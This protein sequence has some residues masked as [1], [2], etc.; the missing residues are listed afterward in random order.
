MS[1][2][3]D[4]DLLFKLIVQGLNSLNETTET[5]D[6]RLD[7]MDKTLAVN[8][9]S[10]VHHVKRTDLLEQQLKPIKSAYDWLVISGKV[11]GILALLVT[12]I[13]GIFAAAKFLLGL[14]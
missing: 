14:V 2:Q 1:N 4:A 6:K 11:I 10:L 5:I 13:S 7:S 3:K 9:E 8:T 12:I